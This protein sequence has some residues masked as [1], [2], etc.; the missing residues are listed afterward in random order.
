MKYEFISPAHH[1][2]YQSSESIVS[3]VKN[4]RYSKQWAGYILGMRQLSPGLQKT[5][6]QRLKTNFSIYK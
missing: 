3:E 4:R 2:P 6:Q 1:H 5:M